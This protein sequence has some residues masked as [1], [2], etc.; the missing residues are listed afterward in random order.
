MTGKTTFAQGQLR[1]LIER[2]ERLNEEKAAISADVKGVYAEAKS[3]GFDTKIMRAIISLRKKDADERQEEEALL[4]VY[5][6]ALGMQPSFFDED[7][8]ETQS[9]VASRPVEGSGGLDTA[10]GAPAAP[11]QEQAPEVFPMGAGKPPTDETVDAVSG[12]LDHVPAKSADL[13]QSENPPLDED[14]ESLAGEVEGARSPVD[15]PSTEISDL[16]IPP[17]LDRRNQIAGVI[18]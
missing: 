16:H 1:S 2:I 4:D 5:M 9:G 17:F 12:A 18:T 6:S 8:S 13:A 10:T 7:Q 15:A 14:Q 11:I 3:A